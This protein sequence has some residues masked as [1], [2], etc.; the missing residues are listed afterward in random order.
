[1]P[2][3]FERGTRIY[4]HLNLYVHTYVHKHME[5]ILGEAAKGNAFIAYLPNTFLSPTTSPSPNSHLPGISA[6]IPDPNQLLRAATEKGKS[7]IGLEKCFF[8]HPMNVEFTST[9][10][11]ILRIWKIGRTK[12]RL[13]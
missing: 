4:T 12:Q 9:P 1:M 3:I 7:Q 2:S 8:Y 10:T 5:G 6:G 13:F 11:K